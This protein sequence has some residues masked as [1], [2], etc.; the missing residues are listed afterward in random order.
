MLFFYKLTTSHNVGRGRFAASSII[1]LPFFS[2]KLLYLK[3]ALLICALFPLNNV[4]LFEFINLQLA[5][6]S[7]S[8]SPRSGVATENALSRGEDGGY[9]FLEYGEEGER[10]TN[11]E[12]NYKFEAGEV[13]A[14]YNTLSNPK[15]GGVQSP[16]YKKFNQWLAGLIDGDGCFQLSKKGYASLEIVAHIRDKNCLYQIKQKFGGSIKVKAN[17][18]HLR[19]RMHHKQGML[20]LIEAVNGE[21][22]NPTRLLQLSKICDKYNI[23]TIGA[24]PLTYEN[25]WLSGF[26]DSD[27]SVYL[28]LKSS[29]MYI[30]AGQ[31][32]KFLLDMLC[33]VYGGTVYIEKISFKWVIYKKSEIIDIL[34]YF[35]LNPC[36][37]AKLNR[38]QAIKKYLELRELKAH[39]QGDSTILGKV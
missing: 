15:G 1:N 24:A 19:Y 14:P 32:N 4:N 37:S 36:R 31:K 38:I 20:N 13:A 39:L 23:P 33:E 18:N 2:F 30:T 28:N 35:K 17:L 3:F 34:E 9:S 26:F 8:P 11:S 6:T 7:S 16:P 27:G 21:I 25:G 10:E 29:Q 5:F 22:R 12:D